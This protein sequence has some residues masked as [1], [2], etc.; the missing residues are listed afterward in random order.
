MDPVIR[1]PAPENGIGR[2]GGAGADGIQEAGGAFGAGRGARAESRQADGRKTASR[3]ARGLR[4]G[5]CTET[6]NGNGNRLE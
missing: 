6:G 4:S 1:P 5:G 2:G 3:P